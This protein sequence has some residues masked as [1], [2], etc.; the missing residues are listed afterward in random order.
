M[1]GAMKF[2]ELSGTQK[3]Q[4]S[5]KTVFLNSDSKQRYGLMP[6]RQYLHDDGTKQSLQR[7]RVPDDSVAC[8]WTTLCKRGPEPPIRLGEKTQ[9]ADSI[10]CCEHLSQLLQP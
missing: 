1:E 6:C 7:F 4:T 10:R 3:K 5:V 9:F 2:S 8:S